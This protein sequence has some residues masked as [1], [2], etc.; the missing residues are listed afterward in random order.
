[1]YKTSVGQCAHDQLT[2]PGVDVQDIATAR[3]QKVYIIR[4]LAAQAKQSVQAGIVIDKYSSFVRESWPTK[5]G[6]TVNAKATTV[7]EKEQH[8]STVLRKVF[9]LSA[10]QQ[11]LFW[12]TERYEGWRTRNSVSLS[13]TE[14][15]QALLTAKL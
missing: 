8:E 13:L 14:L 4:Q 15:R 5:T 3:G 7:D 6:Q 1:M 9:G 11:A 10:E 2:D 12:D